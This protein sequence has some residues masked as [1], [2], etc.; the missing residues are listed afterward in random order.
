MLYKHS[1]WS[2]GALLDDDTIKKTGQLPWQVKQIS[3]K[4]A[5]R[6]QVII[7]DKMITIHRVQSLIFLEVQI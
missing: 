5:T 6:I 4:Q 1:R 3:G 7:V 2:V